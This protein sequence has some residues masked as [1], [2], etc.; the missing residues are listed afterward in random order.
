LDDRHRPAAS[1]D[2][3]LL[4]AGAPAQK[5]EHGTHE[6]ADDRRHSV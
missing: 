6:H 5:A 3:A 4:R 1:I 2:D